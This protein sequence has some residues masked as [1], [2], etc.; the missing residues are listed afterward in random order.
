MLNKIINGILSL[1][2]LAYPFVLLANVMSLAG[3]KVKGTP[4]IVTL[5]FYGFL[6]FSTLYP[7]S[8]IVS[9]AFI[10]RNDFR[11]T[12]IPLLHL[13][14]CGLLFYLWSARRY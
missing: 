11:I 10:K 7:L 8:V 12:L 3:E 13:L 5:I 1:P 14:V 9:W 6:F 2:L 4:F